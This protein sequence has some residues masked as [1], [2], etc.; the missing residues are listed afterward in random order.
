MDLSKFQSLIVANNKFMKRIR[1]TVSRSKRD[2]TDLIFCGQQ[3]SIF[4][5][6][7]AA[8]QVDDLVAVEAAK[9]KLE[10]WVR[11]YQTACIIDGNSTM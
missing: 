11:L 6:I 8:Y 10:S 2:E 5:E 1:D 4:E 9:S 7:V 3:T